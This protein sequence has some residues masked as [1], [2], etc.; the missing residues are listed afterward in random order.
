MNN[1]PFDDSRSH[2][3]LAERAV[4]LEL[5]GAEQQELEDLPS[6]SGFDPDV[7]ERI[8]GVAVIAMNPMPESGLPAAL[9]EKVLKAAPA[10]LAAG[11]IQLRSGQDSSLDAADDGD[12]RIDLLRQQRRWRG[13]VGWLAAAVCLLVMFINRPAAPPVIPT[14]AE[15]RTHLIKF[16]PGTVQWSWSPTADVAATGASGDI[17]WNS[18]RQEGYATLRGLPVQDPEISQ[19]QLWLFDI[20]RDE[21]FP[22]S[23]G[24]FDFNPRN[25]TCV[26][27]LKPGVTVRGPKMFAVTLERAGGVVVSDRSRLLLTASEAASRG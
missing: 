27:A 7:Y 4:F 24:V 20:D 13:L 11:R 25:G 18:S 21:R 10:I 6:S 1:P 26:V 22:I 5:P 3:L 23:A 14:M 19:Y 2:S 8:A 16:E 15:A 9:R 12:E 17:V